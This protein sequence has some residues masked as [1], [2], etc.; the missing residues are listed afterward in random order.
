MR[1][2]TGIYV[3]ASMMNHSCRTIIIN[4]FQGARLIVRATRAVHG[5][6]E[7]S[8]PPWLVIVRAVNGG[9]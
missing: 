6:Q 8:G 3:S 7:V 4:Q 9:Q 1:L 2:A 5:G